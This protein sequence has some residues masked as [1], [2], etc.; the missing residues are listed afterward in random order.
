MFGR[1]TRDG[2]HVLRNE[3]LAG[4]SSHIH[5]ATSRYPLARVSPSF[6][7]R[8]EL[9]VITVVSEGGPMCDSIDIAG[10][11]GVDDLPAGL[12]WP[13]VGLAFDPD[14]DRPLVVDADL[15]VDWFGCATDDEAHTIRLTLVAVDSSKVGQTRPWVKSARLGLAALRRGEAAEA[16]RLLAPGAGKRPRDLVYQ[17]L[18]AAALE[19]SGQRAA[20]EEQVRRIAASSPHRLD[21]SRLKGWR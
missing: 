10:V 3:V 21:E 14:F 17:C 20:Y 4:T 12:A 16:A 7:D 13:L 18:Y 6:G 5:Y 2:A 19:Q 11:I 8:V 9:R 15:F 1:Y